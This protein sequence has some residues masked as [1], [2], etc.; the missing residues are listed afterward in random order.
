LPV[1]QLYQ[2]RPYKDQAK[3]TTKLQELAGGKTL[4][5]VHIG[6]KSSYFEITIETL[7]GRYQRTTQALIQRG[8]DK[9]SIH[10]VWHSQRLPGWIVSTESK[11][12]ENQEKPAGGKI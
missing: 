12:G 3:L 4:P 11:A 2:Q 10:A 9:E 1:E 7:F 8:A 5:P 6:V